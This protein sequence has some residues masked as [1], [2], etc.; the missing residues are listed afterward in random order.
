VQSRPWQEEIRVDEPLARRLIEGATELRPTSL[1]L[2]AAGW[3]NAV[4][5][6]DDFWAFRFPQREKGVP[7]FRRELEI[8]PRLAS[9]LPLPIPAPV[10]IG[11]PVDGYPWPF[12]GARLLRGEE[13]GAARLDD[14]ARVRIA[15]PLARFLRRLHSPEV[16]EAAGAE[17][18]PFDF[19]RRTDMAARG[20]VARSNLADL[21]RLGIWLAPP[22][23]VRLLD[24]ALE[25]PPPE[26]PVLVHGD[27]HFRHVLVDRAGLAG[28]IDWGDVCRADPTVD[29]SLVWSFFP[30]EGRTAFLDEYGEVT[31]AQELRARVLGLSLCAALAG[32]GHDTGS[33]AVKR[34]ALAGLE[35]LAGPS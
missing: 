29:L 3:D 23:V 11:E 13:L 27:L 12:T 17:S 4:W 6:A 22:A 30:P 18:L 35:R 32:Y 7:G 9:L 19:N 33:T 5:V 8:L 21:D 25:L 1:R 26:P 34:E 20:Q 24:D 10:F 15:G 14:E 16:V 2:L 31:E 28:V